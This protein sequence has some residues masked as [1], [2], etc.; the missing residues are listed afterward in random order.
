VART[1][2]SG[3]NP[4]A[5]ASAAEKIRNFFRSYKLSLALRFILGAMIMLSAIP[6]LMDIETNSIYLIY[7]Y[8]VLPIQP[9]NVAR[10]FG[11]VVPY[12]ELLIGLGL[13]FGV[14]TRLSAIGWIIM[15]LAY[16][17]I[18]LVVI[19]VQERIISCGC[20]SSILPDM[21]VTQSI[22]LD[23]ISILFSIQI[24][25]ANR[26]KQLLSFWLLLPEKWQKSKLR[27]IW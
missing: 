14:L 8:Y 26:G 25:L 12:I 2:V 24:V 21:L 13:I 22:W 5:K 10:F 4:I 17:I 16:F 23:V 1:G 7:S 9:V 3:N 11:L 15:S 27:Y 19:F 6:K 18:K 20:F